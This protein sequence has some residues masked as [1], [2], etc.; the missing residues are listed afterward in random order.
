VAAIHWAKF[1]QLPATQKSLSVEEQAQARSGSRAVLPSQE[2][3]TR[4]SCALSYEQSVN[5]T[6][7]ESD[8]FS[9]RYAGRV[10]TG[11][12]S[13]SDPQMA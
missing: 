9:Q 3:G 11:T 2:K 8:S 4:R 5:G 10:E 7:G 13:T 1:Q 6:H 12:W